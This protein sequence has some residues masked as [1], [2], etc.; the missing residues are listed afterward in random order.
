MRRPSRDRLLNL[1]TDLLLD[2]LQE[3]HVEREPD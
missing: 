1:V 3:P 2:G